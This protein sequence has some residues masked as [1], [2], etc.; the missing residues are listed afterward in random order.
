MIHIGNKLLIILSSPTT[1]IIKQLKG[2][3][4]RSL[5]GNSHTLPHS[6]FFFSIMGSWPRDMFSYIKR[7]T[8]KR[9]QWQSSTGICLC[10][11]LRSCLLLT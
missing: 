10:T 2:W 4:S 11:S 5:Y 7:I 9:V 6:H 3:N 8:Q 1:R